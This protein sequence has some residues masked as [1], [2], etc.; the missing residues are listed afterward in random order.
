[1]VINTLGEKLS[2]LL[3][4]DM[5]D[6]DEK[7]YITSSVEFGQVKYS[8]GSILIHKLADD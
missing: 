2:F 3:I 7:V 4:N 1:M 5:V 8:C 6:G